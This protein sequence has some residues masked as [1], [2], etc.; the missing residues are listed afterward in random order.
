MLIR[1]S[2]TST[3]ILRSIGLKFSTAPPPDKSRKLAKP[4]RSTKK[5]DDFWPYADNDNGY[6]TGYFVS[7]VAIKVYVREAGRFLQSARYLHALASLS[8]EYV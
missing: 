3:P 5:N 4:Q 8:S 7:R 6:L 2:N 1:L